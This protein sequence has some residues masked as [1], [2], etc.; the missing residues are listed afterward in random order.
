MPG[1][2]CIKPKMIN[3]TADDTITDNLRFDVYLKKTLI[4]NING[5]NFISSSAIMENISVTIGTISASALPVLA[6][7]L[8][9][10][11]LLIINEYMKYATNIS[12]ASISSSFVGFLKNSE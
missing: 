11:K 6:S 4:R 2:K 10:K 8:A 9:S 1:S 12:T 7:P 5:M 3:V